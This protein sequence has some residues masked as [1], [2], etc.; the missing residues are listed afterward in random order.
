MHGWWIFMG[1]LAAA[2]SALASVHYRR[3]R[4]HRVRLDRIRATVEAWLSVPDGTPQTP[5]A[6]SPPR[7]GSGPHLGAVRR[8]VVLSDSRTLSTT[9]T[10]G[11]RFQ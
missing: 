2:V 3:R 4:A 8:R 7:F 6:V 1:C 5:R 10:S 9:L 11:W